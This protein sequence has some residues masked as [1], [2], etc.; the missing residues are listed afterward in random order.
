MRAEA[1]R[2]KAT[3]GEPGAR[4][5]RSLPRNPGIVLGGLILLALALVAALAP[6]LGTTDPALLDPVNRNKPPGFERTVAG[7]D[8][9]DEDAGVPGEARPD[10]G[11]RARMAEIDRRE[12]G[13][14]DAQ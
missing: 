6:L 1:D 11:A 2:L 13:G 10:P 4:A 14:L 7:P 12:E 9:T 8:G 3:A 5:G